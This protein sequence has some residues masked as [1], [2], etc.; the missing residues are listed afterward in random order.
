M[1]KTGGINV[2]P[3]EI[4]EV[5]LKHPAVQE[6]F[7]CGLPDPVRDQIVAAV[8]VLSSGMRVT[9]E[10]LGRHCREQLAAYKVPRRMRF[11]TMDELPQTASRKVHRLRL[12]TLFQ[13]EP[14]K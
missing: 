2:A 5:L 6:A 3:I 13:P 9:E 11:A 1:L 10:E 4:E 7:V 14:M 8:I 12:Q